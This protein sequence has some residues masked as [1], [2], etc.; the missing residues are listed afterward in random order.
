MIVLSV[1]QENYGDTPEKIAEGLQAICSLIR[2]K[3]P[4]AFLIVLVGHPIP[5]K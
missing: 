5:D 3:Q 1:G 4:Q 2:S